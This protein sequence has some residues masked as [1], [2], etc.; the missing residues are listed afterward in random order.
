MGLYKSTSVAQI[1]KSSYNHYSFVEVMGQEL[2]LE[3][4]FGG[5]Y[6]VDRYTL[7]LKKIHI[8][9]IHMYTTH[10]YFEK[11]TLVPTYIHGARLNQAHANYA[12]LYCSVHKADRFDLKCNNYIKLTIINID[13]IFQRK[14]NSIH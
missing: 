7:Y 9:F 1:K 14:M 6:K 4:F 11:L 8:L 13:V 3:F 12:F 2:E 10:G 5:D